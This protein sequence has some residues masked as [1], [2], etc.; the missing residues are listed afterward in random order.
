M[1][2]EWGI[3]HDACRADDRFPQGAVPVG[4]SVNVTLRVDGAVRWR[5]HRADALVCEDGAW[6]E[7]CMD[8]SDRGFTANL[9][10]DARPH[11]VFY[12]FKLTV[13]DEAVAYYVPRTDGRATSGELVWPEDDGEW[14]DA[15]WQHFE[16]RRIYSVYQSLGKG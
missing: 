12:V 6:R 8:L 3:A 11:V 4:T 14:G 10:L 13:D 2:L 9:Q 15:G 5:V 7:V 1:D 16:R